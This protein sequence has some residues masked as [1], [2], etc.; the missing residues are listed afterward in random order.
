[1]A[2][3]NMDLLNKM[4]KQLED[5]TSGNLIYASKIKGKMDIRIL[6]PHPEMDGVIYFER[7]CWSVGDKV[8]TSAETFGSPCVIEE[9]VSL[10]KVLVDRYKSSKN[11]EER[12]FAVDL[13][14]LLNSWKDCKKRSE[15][16]IPVLVVHDAED[17]VTVS[18][19][20]LFSCSVSIVQQLVDVMTNRKYLNGTPNGVADRVKGRNFE[21]SKK[22]EG[23][24][25]EYA[26]VPWPE[27]MEMPEQYYSD[28][29][30]P[31]PVEYVRKGL[32]S[33]AYLRSLIRNYLYGEE[34]VEDGAE[35]DTPSVEQKPKVLSGGN[36]PVAK[37]V[38]LSAKRVVTPAAPIAAEEEN[39]DQPEGEDGSSTQPNT[40]F[41]TPSISTVIKK[42]ASLPKPTGKPTIPGGA[43]RNILGDLK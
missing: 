12:E 19:P 39:N 31:N 14:K 32:K 16:L 20:K 11:K 13:S 7:V 41:D 25:T 1:M 17:S 3:V 8:V 34:I 28:A 10:A 35:Q 43:K 6:P 42:G 2:N 33:D 36:Q 37:S 27:A 26:A 4:K 40:S 5:K 22:G 29:V 18:E 21:V 38:N 15:Y 9:E 24:E 30:I 23:K